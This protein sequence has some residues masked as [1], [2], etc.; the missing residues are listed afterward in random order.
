MSTSRLSR[1]IVFSALLVAGATLAVSAPAAAE[2]T[3]DVYLVQGVPGARV[4]ISVD[5]DQVGSAVKAKDVIGPIE[6]SAGTH[7]VS[8]EADGWA[9]GTSF[10]ADAESIDL[11]VHWPADATQSPDV[12]VFVNDV[13]PV[14]ADKARLT[15]A[16]TAV[17]PPADIV[18][19]GQVLFSNIANGEFVTADVPAATYE[20]SVVPAGQSGDPL[21]GP[22][23]LDVE[24]GRLTRVF[25]IGE[26]Q[27]GSMDAVVQVL[28]LGE[29]GSEAPGSIDA[30]EAGLV[31]TD[32]T[33]GADL[34]GLTTV[35]AGGLVGAVA[36][37]AVRRRRA[38]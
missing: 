28:P 32:G 9:V 29:T 3:T 7:E 22:V 1:S 33:A 34:G 35:V 38:T 8:F 16:H 4:D 21:L 6:L 37:L 2:G 19:D 36:V 11:V 23:A 17:V 24:A 15:V 5:G 13:A 30:G 18:A 14:P 25:A 10:E 27:D 31:A 12:T 26:P 20:V